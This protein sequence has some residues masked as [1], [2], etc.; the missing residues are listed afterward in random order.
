MTYDV[1]FPDSGQVGVEVAFDLV[2]QPDA[3]DFPATAFDFIAGLVIQAVEFRVVE[4]FFGLL[5]SVVGRLVRTKESA[6]GESP[7]ALLCE[8]H[9]AK[10]GKGG[11]RGGRLFHQSPAAQV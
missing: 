8:R 4:G 5:Q 6:V 7:M 9:G 2:V 1:V 10:R 11:I 3:D